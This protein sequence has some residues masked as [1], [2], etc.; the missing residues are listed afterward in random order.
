MFTGK[1][2]LRYSRIV[3]LMMYGMIGLNLG[4]VTHGAV[5]PVSDAELSGS[6]ASQCPTNLASLEPE[7]K[8]ALR[9]ITSST[10]RDTMMASLQ[11]SIP[12]AI[13]Q[14]DGIAKQIT[15]LKQE[16]LRQERERQHA[17]RVA[18]EHAKDPNKPLAPCRRRDESSYCY[19][20]N[21]YLVSTA[22]NLANEAFLKALQCYQQEGKR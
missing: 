3:G 22:A 5:F 10:F 16:I 13:E 8:K 18:R 15:F 21:Q 4:Q 12:E 1:S 14:A 7:M 6:P 17:E 19:A 11:A 9:Y 20:M 2:V